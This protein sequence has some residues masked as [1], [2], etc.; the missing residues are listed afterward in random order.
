LTIVTSLIPSI[1]LQYKLALRS[2]KEGRG[3]EWVKAELT[4]D[5]DDKCIVRGDLVVKWLFHNSHRVL[6][7]LRC[8]EY[9]T[10]WQTRR[11]VSATYYYSNRLRRKHR[12][13]SDTCHY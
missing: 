3:V 1:H 2:V 10:A 12:N 11:R 4:P 13:T 7:N 9:N 6:N 8:S 5:S